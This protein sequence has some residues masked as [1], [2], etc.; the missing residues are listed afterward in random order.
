[1]K[2]A[3]ID[4]C[5]SRIA[6]SFTWKTLHH[7]C[8]SWLFQSILEQVFLRTLGSDFIFAEIV[9]SAPKLESFG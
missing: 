1:M 2:I 6:F 7:R 4:S 3:K 9:S 5:G 8:F